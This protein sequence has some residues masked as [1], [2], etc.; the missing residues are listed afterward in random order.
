MKPIKSAIELETEPSVGLAV[1]ILGILAACLILSG[2]WLQGGILWLS[3][4]ILGI[5]V[6]AK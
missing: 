3:D 2:R 6:F 1:F 5:V 4:L